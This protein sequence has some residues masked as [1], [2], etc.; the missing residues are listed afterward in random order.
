MSEQTK[1]EPPVFIRYLLGLNPEKDR[2]VLAV[3]RK[4]ASPATETYAWPHLGRFCHL[5]VDTE[6]MIH[7]AIAAAYA[8]HPEND[9]TEFANVGSVMCQLANLSGEREN[10]VCQTFD[11]FF[12]RLLTCN[13]VEEICERLPRI[14]LMAKAKDVAIPWESLYW[15]LK[16][17]NNNSNEIKRKWAAKYWQVPKQMD[18][19]SESEDETEDSDDSSDTEVES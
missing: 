19:L 2:G 11:T 4:G 13:S 8:I 18:D 9:E 12:R 1:R 16:T 5:N 15:D 17:W 3:L 10:N 14:A 6:R 7:Q